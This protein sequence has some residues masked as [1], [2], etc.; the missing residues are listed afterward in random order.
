[1]S[2]VRATL[3]T[4]AIALGAVAP[5]GAA[6]EPV[7]EIQFICDLIGPEDLARVPGG[8]WVIASGNQ[9]GGRLH[10][11]HVRDGASTKRTARFWANF[12]RRYRKE[13]LPL[14]A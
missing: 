12:A 8:E 3:T 7:G 2:A 1:M 5:S 9:E 4:V 11:V 14:C 13:V 6:C 10:A